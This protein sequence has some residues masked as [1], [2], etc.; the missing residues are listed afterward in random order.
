[1]LSRRLPNASEMAKPVRHF[2]ENAEKHQLGEVASAT[3]F[4][5]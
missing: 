4:E 5:N 3:R 1:M 2:D